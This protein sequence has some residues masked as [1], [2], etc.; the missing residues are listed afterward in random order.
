MKIGH[1]IVMGMALMVALV[2]AISG[3][4][5]YATARM[6]A[7]IQQLLSEDIPTMRRIQEVLASTTAIA[8]AQQRYVYFGDAQSLKTV[9]S[10][11]GRLSALIAELPPGNNRQDA[12]D[13]ADLRRQAARFIQQQEDAIR[14]FQ[15]GDM[16]L[17][18][19]EGG[20]GGAEMHDAI[21]EDCS[22]LLVSYRI[23]LLSHQTTYLNMGRS[24][25]AVSI[26]IACA[27]V[28]LAMTLTTLGTRAIILPLNRLVQTTQLIRRGDLS[29]RAEQG[30]P[31]EVGE[32]AL[33]MNKMVSELQQHIDAVNQ[34]KSALTASN[35]ELLHRT[36]QL[37]RELRFARQVQRSIVPRGAMVDG[38]RCFAHIR[39][40]REVGGDFYDLVQFRDS[41]SFCCVL[42]DV[43]GK[44]IP[45]ALMMVLSLTILRE[46]YRMSQ[47]PAELF[48]I[49][50]DRIRE[51][52]VDD[53]MPKGVSAA[54]LVIDM[55]QRVMRF[56]KAGHEEILWYRA[57]HAAIEVLSAEGV[58]LG[59]FPDEVWEERMVQ[60]APGDR[61]VLYTDG[62]TE[63]RNGA[64]ELYG[65]E[66]LMDA[67]R[68]TA[69]LDVDAMGERLLAGVTEFTGGGEPSDDIALVILEIA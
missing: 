50:N 60:L 47:S 54:A 23:N 53:D 29:R 68:S 26:A 12:S 2:V 64:Q 39:P 62:I 20:P 52:V 3:F 58:F 36:E 33:S 42:G 10:E 7:V 15:E 40:A 14:F 44:G 61:L 55:R 30:A 24:L 21:A 34:A 32:L 1:R 41:D 48:R 46:A 37:F 49:T 31:G 28:L 57:A 22:R 35:L 8:V 4:A 27:A 69:T 9:R 17:A 59:I 16:D 66:R 25:K 5:M 65:V 6:D 38:V 45:A 67:V 11:I 63:A 56:A 18:R 19:F 43:M 51:Q 13:Y